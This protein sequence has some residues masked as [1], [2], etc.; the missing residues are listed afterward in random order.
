MLWMLDGSVGMCLQAVHLVDF[1]VA[2][3]ELCFTYEVSLRKGP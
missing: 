3:L 1:E 2:Q